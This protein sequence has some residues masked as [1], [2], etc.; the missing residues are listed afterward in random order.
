MFILDIY[1][2]LKTVGFFINLVSNS[3]IKTA[4]GIETLGYFDHEERVLAVALHNPYWIM[5][6]I[7][8]YSHFKQWQEGMFNNELLTEAYEKYDPWLSHEIELTPEEVKKFTTAIQE[9]E[10]DAERRTL[11]FATEHF[12]DE[13]WEDTNTSIEQYS[14]ASNSYI[15]FYSL[16]AKHRSWYSRS[17]PSYTEETRSLCPTVLIT[18]VNTELPVGYEEAVIKHCF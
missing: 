3:K 4:Q 18:D 16:V 7:H 12:T 15:F 5:T 9:L 11:Q 8:E 2:E 17:G 10:L 13:D 1:R 6:L 14:Q